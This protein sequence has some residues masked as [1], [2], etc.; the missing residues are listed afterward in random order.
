MSVFGG[1]DRILLEEI[2]EATEQSEAELCGSVETVD[3]GSV[4]TSVTVA[5]VAD[6]QEQQPQ[7]QQPPQSK[8]NGTGRRVA[9]QNVGLSNGNG[10]SNVGRVTP[11]SHMEQEKRIRREIANSNERRR[12]QSINAGFQSL[13]TL[14]PHHE[15]EKLS[16]VSRCSALCKVRSIVGTEH[17]S[18]RI[19]LSRLYE[20]S[21]VLARSRAR[22]REREREREKLWRLAATCP[23][24]A[25]IIQRRSRTGS[26]PFAS[27]AGGWL[28]RLDN[29][30]ASR[31]KGTKARRG[32]RRERA[33]KRAKG[34]RAT[35]CDV[36]VR[37]N[38]DTQRRANRDDEAAANNERCLPARSARFLHSLDYSQG[39]NCHRQ[40]GPYPQ[41]NASAGRSVG[42][43]FSF[44]AR[45][46]GEKKTKKRKRR[47]C[48]ARS[49][50]NSG[51]PSLRPLV[52][53]LS[54]ATAPPPPCSSSVLSSR[55]L[56]LSS[57]RLSLRHYGR[58]AALP[59]PRFLFSPRKWTKLRRPRVHC[60][61]RPSS[62]SWRR[63]QLGC[64][65]VHAIRHFSLTRQRPKHF[66]ANRT[67]TVIFRASVQVQGRRAF[68][69][70]EKTDV[71][72]W[73]RKRR[74]FFMSVFS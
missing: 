21:L 34:P 44:R 3:D 64:S 45:I 40:S 42:S 37:L 1:D 74:S 20:Y 39:Y 71:K 52:A 58:R 35:G 10:V 33:S 28:A 70:K 30:A 2:V 6:T 55:A 67:G 62:Y 66:Y 51:G 8:G 13:R 41:R 65:A 43:E 4:T 48:V 27:L 19:L 12:M 63:P 61:L 25:A 31:V 57:L 17:F 60:A 29:L 36:L 72:T 18:I 50:R 53:A 23:K 49:E 7:Q 69:G 56:R 26:I 5:E 68:V 11:R 38:I 24:V 22:K 14:L 15:G 46:G 73:L 9:S 16:K 59:F 47:D 54:L 32:A